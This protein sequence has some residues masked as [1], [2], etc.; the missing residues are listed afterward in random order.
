LSET[1]TLTATRRTAADP[2]RV[3]LSVPVLGS[4]CRSTAFCVEAIEGLR[5]ATEARLD[6]EPWKSDARD[7]EIYSRAASVR[8]AGRTFETRATTGSMALARS[9]GGASRRIDHGTLHLREI[10]WFSSDG[11]RRLAVSA[12]LNIDDG[13]LSQRVGHV[14]GDIRAY[15]SDAGALVAFAPLPWLKTVFA[16]VVGKPYS[17]AG[18]VRFAPGRF[19]LEDARLSAA[20]LLVRGAHRSYDG[21]RSGAFLFR[22]AKW[23]IGAVFDESGVRTRF[24]VGERWLERQSSAPSH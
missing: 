10:D 4:D 23:S 13:L 17:F 14:H 5:M 21:E 3:E 19:E 15:G 20:R 2:V 6:G 9:D 11:R 8:V 16:G 18:S 1:V 24:G 22:Y 12:S 7:V